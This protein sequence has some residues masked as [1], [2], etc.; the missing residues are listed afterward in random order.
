MAARSVGNT[1]TIIAASA[2]AM[3]ICMKVE[4][5][6]WDATALTELVTAMPTRVPRMRPVRDERVS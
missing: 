1:R 3:A 6:V 5:E 2:T 4:T